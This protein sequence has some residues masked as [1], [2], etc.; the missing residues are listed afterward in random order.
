MMHTHTALQEYQYKYFVKHKKQVFW[1]Q[2]TRFSTMRIVTVTSKN[3]SV[4]FVL[5]FF[6]TH[7]PTK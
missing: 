6:T 1:Y 2:N 5:I 4:P 7:Q 3:C